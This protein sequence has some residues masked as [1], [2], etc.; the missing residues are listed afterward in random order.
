[1]GG[2]SSRAMPMPSQRASTGRWAIFRDVVSTGSYMVSG[3]VTA[4]RRCIWLRALPDQIKSFELRPYQS[5]G[6]I[7]SGRALGRSLSRCAH[8][9]VFGVNN[10]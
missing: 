10:V 6:S 7:C 1:L 9:R 8:G 4:Y 5:N 3:T 2:K